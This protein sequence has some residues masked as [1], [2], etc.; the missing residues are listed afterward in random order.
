MGDRYKRNEPSPVLVIAL[1]FLVLLCIGL[2]V[3][4]FV[5]F[6]EQSKLE[7]RIAEEHKSAQAAKDARDW[8]HYVRLMYQSAIGFSL[9]KDEEEALGL[10]QKRYW[11]ASSARAS[12]TGKRSTKSSRGSWM[13]S[14]STR[15][16][17]LSERTSPRKH[18]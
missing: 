13:T 15:R 9:S 11:K 16:W 2:G 3:A 17:A 4:T 1:V 12:R 10:L 6:S 5:G 8:E 14:T 18:E 7:A